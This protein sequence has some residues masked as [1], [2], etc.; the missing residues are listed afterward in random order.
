MKNSI[1]TMDIS[2]LLNTDFRN[3]NDW[4][5]ISKNDCSIYNTIYIFLKCTSPIG[6]KTKTYFL[7]KIKAI[8][9]NQRFG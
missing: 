9:Q 1:K 6:K 7:V 4:S 2:S 8:F 3:L 5:L